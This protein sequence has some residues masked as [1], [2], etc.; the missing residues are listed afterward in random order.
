MVRNGNS[1]K[2]F[3]VPKKIRARKTRA[4]S[5]P[6]KVSRIDF[7]GKGEWCVGRGLEITNPSLAGFTVQTRSTYASTCDRMCVIYTSVQHAH[8]AS[9][10][11]ASQPTFTLRLTA[12]GIDGKKK[13]KIGHH[14]FQP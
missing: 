10:A 8:V 9:A 7:V 4:L 14:E 3:V 1:M 12:I 6:R 5:L 13:K 2:G 11:R